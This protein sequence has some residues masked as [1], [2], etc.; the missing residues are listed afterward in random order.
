MTR[1]GERLVGRL[2]TLTGLACLVI[3]LFHLLG[4]ASRTT[5]GAGQV[6]ASIDSQ[7]RFYATLF[8]GYGLAW[9]RAARTEPVPATDVVTLSSIMAVGGLGR[10][11]SWKQSGRPH[12][13]YVVLTAVEFV[14]PVVTLRALR[15]SRA[16]SAC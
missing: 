4:G 10:L 12:P 15:R 1:G 14:V 7:E 16:T 2:S 3:G 9:L 13:L 5:P 11:L 6:S 8:A